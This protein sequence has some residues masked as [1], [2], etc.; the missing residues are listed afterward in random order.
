[1]GK[2]FEK[3]QDSLLA[4]IHCYLALALMK[5]VPAAQYPDASQLKAVE[6]SS[7][8]KFND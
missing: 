1:V 6:V 5:A 8:G 7:C 4:E 2:Q 3:Y